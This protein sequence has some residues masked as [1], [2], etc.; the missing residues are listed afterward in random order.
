MSSYGIG[1]FSV[2]MTVL[3]IIFILS[4][5]HKP[6][7][8]KDNPQKKDFDERQ[9][10]LRNK[11]YKYAYSIL[12][13]YTILKLLW[14]AVRNAG[15][16]HIILSFAAICLTI[17]VHSSYS[18][19][20]DAYFPL[21]QKPKGSLAFLLIMAVSQLLIGMAELRQR[22]SFLQMERELSKN[23]GSAELA[24]LADLFGS[25]SVPLSQPLCS[26]IVGASALIIA[27]VSLLRMVYNKKTEGPEE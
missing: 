27:A 4:L 16:E 15:E 2:G 9:D 17:V 12:A 21:R 22:D 3:T 13:C 25:Q 10:I 26:F 18:I 23:A 24:E 7:L 14:D 5:F 1:Y 20:H 19:W 8:K 6:F 11:G